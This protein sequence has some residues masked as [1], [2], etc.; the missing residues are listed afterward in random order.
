M[1]EILSA[2]PAGP[3][4]SSSAEPWATIALELHGEAHAVPYDPP[5]VGHAG[6]P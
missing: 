3:V 6:F 4:K 1:A 2:V 5:I